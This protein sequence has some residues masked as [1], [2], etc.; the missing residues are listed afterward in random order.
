M[1]TC[2]SWLACAQGVTVML[3]RAHS[4]HTKPPPP[5]AIRAR[6]LAPST[7]PTTLRGALD[8]AATAAYAPAAGIAAN[9]TADATR[10]R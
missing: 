9:D 1:W 3:P 6:F 2:P 5:R 8:T 4:S 10:H 7:P